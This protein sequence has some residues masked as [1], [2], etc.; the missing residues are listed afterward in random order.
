MVR[1]RYHN[2]PAGK[3]MNSARS[4]Q[5]QVSNFHHL[6]G[7]KLKPWNH[8]WQSQFEAVPSPESTKFKSTT[9]PARRSC[10]DP[11]IYSCSTT[12]KMAL[13][14]LQEER[15]EQGNTCST[16]GRG[17]KWEWGYV[18]SELKLSLTNPTPPLAKHV[19]LAG[20][21]TAHAL[22]PLLVEIN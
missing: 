2:K 21:P 7:G 9:L 13:S 15:K 3:E 5:P 4:R 19:A 10:P 12:S 17:I 20:V 22:F 6:G 18:V 11:F 8:P 14:Y 1:E 16:R